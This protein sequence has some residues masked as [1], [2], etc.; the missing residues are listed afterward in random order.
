MSG[1]SVGN[2]PAELTSFVGRR[3]ALTHAKN[4]LASARLL[5]LTGVGGIGKTRFAR[6]LASEVRRT[7][8]DGVWLVE[9]ADLRQ[10]GLL[11]QTV[12]SALGI[13]DESSDPVG[14]LID[15]LRERRLLLILDN[16]EH[17]AESC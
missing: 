5:T 10:G 1:S 17:M 4:L 13:R 3:E 15:Y 9:L 12:S 2:L 11:A 8:A 14:T 16:C 7:F 6:R